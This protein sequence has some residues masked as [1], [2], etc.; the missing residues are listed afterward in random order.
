M[1]IYFVSH[2]SNAN[3]ALRIVR[4]SLDIAAPWVAHFGA[5]IS[6]RFLSSRHNLRVCGA[7]VLDICWSACERST[8]VSSFVYCEASL[9]GQPQGRVRVQRA[10]FT[11]WAWDFSELS[12]LL[13]LGR[14]LFVVRKIFPRVL[15]RETG[16][17][18]VEV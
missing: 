10:R 12:G 7:C 4:C 15:L 3:F 1:F 9:L 8:V 14:Q 17:T 16:W 2:N 11:E 6:A 13:T 5:D 18:C